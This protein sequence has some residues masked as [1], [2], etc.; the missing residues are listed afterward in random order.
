[1]PICIPKITA[2]VDREAAKLAILWFSLPRAAPVPI[3]LVGGDVD[4]VEDIMFVFEHYTG[5]IRFLRLFASCVNV[6]VLAPPC[7]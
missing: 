5:A 1:M 3:V 6:L 2:A 7:S 4:S